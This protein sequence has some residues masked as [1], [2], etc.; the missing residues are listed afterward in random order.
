MSEEC[1]KENHK[2]KGEE[3]Q[4]NTQTHKIKKTYLIWHSEFTVETNEYIEYRSLKGKDY[5]WS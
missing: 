1:G 5:F 3:T 4:T 2:Y